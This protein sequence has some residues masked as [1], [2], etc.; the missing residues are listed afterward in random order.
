LQSNTMSEVF[1]SAPSFPTPPPY[2]FPPETSECKRLDDVEQPIVSVDDSTKPLIVCKCSDKLPYSF[3]GFSNEKL[4]HFFLLFL[5]VLFA[6][7]GVVFFFLLGVGVGC[8]NIIVV[9]IGATGTTTS[10]AFSIGM[11]I[12]KKDMEKRNTHGLSILIGV[13]IWFAVGCVVILLTASAS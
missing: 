6:V 5:L 1:P 7:L 9:I 4:A 2:E 11:F 3:C 12:V 8:H 13:L 10:I